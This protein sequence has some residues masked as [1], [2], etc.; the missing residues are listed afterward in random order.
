MVQHHLVRLTA[1]ARFLVAAETGRGV[2]Q[3]RGVDPHH[4]SLHLR[5]GIDGFW[6]AMGWPL[7]TNAVL[8]QV[9]FL[10]AVAGLA[11]VRQQAQFALCDLGAVSVLADVA[12]SPDSRLARQHAIYLEA[13]R[14][15][16]RIRRPRNVADLL[17]RGHRSKNTKQTAHLVDVIV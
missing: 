14:S 2:E 9:L 7:Y 11:R 3:V 1:D 10:M 8:A 15:D 16:R 6:D 13:Q 5:G 17:E 12:K 4:A